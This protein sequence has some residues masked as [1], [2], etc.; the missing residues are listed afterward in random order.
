L[1]LAL[2]FLRNKNQCSGFRSLIYKIGIMN[3]SLL[4]FRLWLH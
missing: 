3:N 1:R 2:F 4:Y